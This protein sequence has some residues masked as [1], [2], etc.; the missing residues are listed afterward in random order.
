MTPC[1][2]LARI[3]NPC[4]QQLLYPSLCDECFPLLERDFLSRSLFLISPQPISLRKNGSE[5]AGSGVK[6][7][8]DNGSGFSALIFFGSFLYQDKKERVNRSLQCL[9]GAMQSFTL[10]L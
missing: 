3:C 9:T 8:P 2:L 1:T 5:E 10:A 6:A 7:W 4:Y